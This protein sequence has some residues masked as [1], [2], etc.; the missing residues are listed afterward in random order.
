M[1]DVHLPTTDG[2]EL[3]MPHYTQPEKEHFMILEKIGLE[4]PAQPP[5]RISAP[6]PEIAPPGCSEDRQVMFL[7]TSITYVSKNPPTE[8]SFKFF[9]F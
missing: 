1:I 7:E 8:N 2:R 9:F 3:L 6:A 5:P 4:F